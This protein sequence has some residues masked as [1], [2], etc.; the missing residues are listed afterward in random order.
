ME[1]FATTRLPAIQE[2]GAKESDQKETRVKKTSSKK[3]VRPTS[4]RAK[5]GLPHGLSFV[6]MGAKI[7][8]SFSNL[9][10]AEWHPGVTLCHR[11]GRLW[12]MTQSE[13]FSIGD[14]CKQCSKEASG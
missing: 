9:P 2:V 4:V 5:K 11:K 1:R 3:N 13:R 14:V 10:L 8:M 7:H 12:R 6:R